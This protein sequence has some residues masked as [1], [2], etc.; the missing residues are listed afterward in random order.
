MGRAGSRTAG[1]RACPLVSVLALAACGSGTTTFPGAPP[2]P[3]GIPQVNLGPAVDAKTLCGV[4]KESAFASVDSLNDRVVVWMVTIAGDPAWQVTPSGT[5]DANFTSTGSATVASAT[6]TPPAAAVPGDTYD[7]VATVVALDG[8]FPTGMVALHGEVVAPVVAVDQTTLDFGDVPPLTPTTM[9][10]SLLNQ[11]VA[12]VSLSPPQGADPFFYATPLDP[13]AHDARAPLNVVV[14][15]LPG[16]YTRD[17]AWKA[18]PPMTTQVLDP[19]CSV[20]T[21]MTVHAR[22]VAPA[23]DGG[24]A[25]GGGDAGGP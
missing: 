15:G 20:L 23:G 12:G 22:I 8:S 14:S 4:P 6:F 24:D 7:A 13:I 3:P 16:D 1:R 19:A 10:A 18:S 17:I 5:H 9:T 2:S 21:K 25:D 11:S